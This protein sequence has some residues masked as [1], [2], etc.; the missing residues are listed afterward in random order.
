MKKNIYIKKKDMNKISKVG[1]PRLY[2][3]CLVMLKTNE[4][5]IAHLMSNHQ[6]CSDTNGCW[7]SEGDNHWYALDGNPE[8][9]VYLTEY[10]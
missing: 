3:T 8:Y 6:C 10:N 7:D 5:R 2:E 1:L 4:Y 9:W